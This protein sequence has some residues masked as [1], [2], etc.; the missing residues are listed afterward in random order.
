[1]FANVGDVTQKVGTRVSVSTL[2]PERVSHPRLSTHTTTVIWSPSSRVDRIYS[3]TMQ[4]NTLDHVR[5]LYMLGIV[6]VYYWNGSPALR[7]PGDAHGH[8]F[9]SVTSLGPSV[10]AIN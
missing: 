6:L 1:M 7:G 9:T 4:T 10:V 2:S 8:G 5:T 3:V